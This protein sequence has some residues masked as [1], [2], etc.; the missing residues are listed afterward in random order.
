MKYSALVDTLERANKRTNTIQLEDGTRV[1]ILIHGGRVL[2]LFS[3]DNEEN[4]YWTHPALSS[5]DS[6]IAF[7]GSGVWENS[8]GDRTWLAPETDLFFPRYP[9]LEM[10]GYLQPR[11]L[12]PGNYRLLPT[13]DGTLRI[14]NRFT[15]ELFRSKT[16][17]EVELTK[18]IVST[19]NPLRHERDL[20][21]I[22]KVDFFGYQQHT[23]LQL[24]EGKSR[25]GLWNLV[26]MP[27]SGDMIIPTF[28]KSQ[29]K[30]Y[31]GD[32]DPDRLFVGDNCICWSM[33]DTGEQKIGV[34]AVGSAGR[35]GYMYDSDGSSTLIVR[36]F[37]VNPAGDYVDTPWTDQEDFGYAVQACNVNSSL[38]RFSELEYHV[39]AIGE[40]TGLNRCDDVSQVWAFRGARPLLKEVAQSLLGRSP[41]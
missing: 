8:G 13:Q 35:V 38:G 32:I 36:N 29:P 4:A 17:V 24:L 21:D 12:D 2:G 10:D 34:R 22:E 14:A 3:R 5:A 18:H 11:Q 6:A 31:F 19:S 9:S 41:A 15:V 1:L 39:P 27:H 23:S 25:V 30:I 28:L 37:F 40:G 26:Q 7:Y 16:S 20:F 33:Q